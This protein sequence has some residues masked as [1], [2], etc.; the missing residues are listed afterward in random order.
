[1]SKSML[2]SINKGKSKKSTSASVAA[3]ASRDPG[4]KPREAAPLSQLS[5][6]GSSGIDMS[7]LSSERLAQILENT[8][9]ARV[10]ENSD[11]GA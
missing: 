3:I 10:G 2:E 7:W 11:L 8:G 5:Q 4:Y 1:M 6:A 9:I